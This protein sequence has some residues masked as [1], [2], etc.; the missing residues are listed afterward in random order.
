MPSS[1]QISNTQSRNA[2]LTLLPQAKRRRGLGS[3]VGGPASSAFFGRK[4]W[5]N[6]PR[7]TLINFC[8]SL[9]RNVPFH[10]SNPARNALLL[11]ALRPPHPRLPQDPP[12]WQPSAQHPWPHH[13]KQ[14]HHATQVLSNA[15]MRC[16]LDSLGQQPRRRVI[17]QIVSS[18]PRMTELN[19]V[20]I[21][22]PMNSRAVFGGIISMPIIA[23][24]AAGYS[25]MI[26]S[27]PCL[28]GA[29]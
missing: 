16:Y 27:T 1:R 17:T 10:F 5:A 9:S 7:I 23:A 4:K 14:T 13:V 20:H 29:S 18:G 24:M 2:A 3:A 26:S 22:R 8:I 11:H 15:G 25:Q 12:H 28:S 19:T 21:I 6:R